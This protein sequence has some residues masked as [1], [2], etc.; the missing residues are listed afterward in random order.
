MY[1]SRAELCFHNADNSLS[2]LS[3]LTETLLCQRFELVLPEQ[4]SSIHSAVALTVHTGRSAEASGI[5]MAE[6]AAQEGSRD[7][8]QKPAMHDLDQDVLNMVFS[9]LEPDVLARAG[10]Q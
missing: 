3:I 4:L 9:K 2:V 6:G 1:V 8:R 7:A 5:C 10:L